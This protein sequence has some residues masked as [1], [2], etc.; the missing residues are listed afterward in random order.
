MNSPMRSAGIDIGSRSIELVVLENGEIV[1]LKTVPAG[2]DPLSTATSLLEGTHFESL[3]ATG[4]GRHLLEV[5][6]DVKTVTEIKAYALGAL[7]VL[8]S[9]RTVLDIGGQDVKAIAVGEDGRVRKFDMNDRCAAGSG[10]FLEIMAQTLG[11]TLPEFGA[12]ALTSTNEVTINSMCTVFAES[13]ATSL[14]NKG[15]ARQDIALALHRSVVKRAIAML[16]RVS[17]SGPVLFAGGGALNPCL[18]R[19]LEESL[20]LAVHVPDNPQSI[21]ALGAALLAAAPGGR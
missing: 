8:P 6:R 19:V 2:F 20:G 7:A 9:C 5:A 21:G 16:N 3:V 12:A 1:H 10:K 11:F 18:H 4:Y 15:V 13:E 17:I 14:V